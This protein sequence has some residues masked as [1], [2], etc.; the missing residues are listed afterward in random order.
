VSSPAP[1]ALH[2]PRHCR[3]AARIIRSLQRLDTGFEWTE[4]FD[5]TGRG[6]VRVPGSWRL[7]YRDGGGWTPVD[8]RD[9]F[10][11]AKGRYN[12]VTFTPVTTT[13]LRIDVV[14][15]R[16]WSVGIQEWKVK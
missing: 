7:S 2:R 9:A 4:G 12:R 11:V 8:S 3:L 15:Q 5:D 16:E 10:G 6:Q 13:A 1:T 14:A